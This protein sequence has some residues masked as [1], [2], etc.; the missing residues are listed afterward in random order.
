MKLC[1]VDRYWDWHYGFETS[2]SRRQTSSSKK[3]TKTVSIANK[4]D[5]DSYS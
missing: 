3:D 5:R 4:K 1:G 2:Y